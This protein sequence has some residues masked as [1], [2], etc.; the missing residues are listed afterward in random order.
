MTDPWTQRVFLSW[1][2]MMSYYENRLA[3]LR[4]FEDEG[5]LWQM[6]ITQDRV[7]ARLGDAS[8]LLKF[9]PEQVELALLQPKG[10]V[11]RL[12]E[13]LGRVWGAVRPQRVARA[14]LSFQ[15]L[16]PLNMSYEAAR[17]TAVTSLF[18]GPTAATFN[19][20]SAILT[21]EEKEPGVQ[22][23]CEFGVVEA[24]EA[25]RRLGR[26]IGFFQGQSADTPSTIWPVESLPEVAFFFDGVWQ[27][28]HLREPSHTGMLTTWR[29]TRERVQGVVFMLMD[30]I[31][32]AY[33]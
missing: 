33:E 3:V 13:A 20:W 32:L 26:E 29:E 16:V 2:T 9:S 1:R 21:G 27:I 6:Q 5:L 28:A 19:D 31:G 22:Y 24:A 7:S 23:L 25:P 8:H 17:T 14:R 12:E 4:S 10:D 11:A 30:A 18:G 15:W